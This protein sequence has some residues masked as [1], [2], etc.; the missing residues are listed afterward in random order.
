M[1]LR[2]V[3]A[4]DLLCYLHFDFIAHKALEAAQMNVKQRS[5]TL[6]TEKP[7]RSDSKSKMAAGCSLE[8]GQLTTLFLSTYRH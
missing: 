2:V 4:V 7:V 5:Y 8:V 3:H 1:R 6:Y